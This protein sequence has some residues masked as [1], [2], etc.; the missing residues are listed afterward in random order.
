MKSLF[1]Q[2]FISYYLYVSGSLNNI[3]FETYNHKIDNHLQTFYDNSSNLTNNNN[4]VFLVYELRKQYGKL[5]AVKDVSFGVNQHECFGLLGVNGAGK[6]TTF[7]MMTGG[8]VPNS[9]TMFIGDKSFKANLS[10]VCHIM[11]IFCLMKLS[12]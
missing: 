1:S 4:Q 2:N 8:E 10:S 5:L 9:G 3:N 6:S 11:N 12:N 7:K